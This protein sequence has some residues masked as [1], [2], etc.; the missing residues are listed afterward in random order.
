MQQFLEVIKVSVH[1]GN[2]SSSPGE[3]GVAALAS[4]SALLKS[5]TPVVATATN[6]RKPVCKTCGK[7]RKGHPKDPCIASSVPETENAV[8]SSQRRS[9]EYAEREG[10]QPTLVPVGEDDTAGG[11]D[12]NH[13]DGSEEVAGV[14][15]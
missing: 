12:L 6:R 15:M 4:A 7:I 5:A 1:S 11:L 9:S 8:G 2:S 14:R 3:S 13:Q 10:D